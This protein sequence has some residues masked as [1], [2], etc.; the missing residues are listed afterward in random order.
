MLNN[1]I[2]SAE[3]EFNFKSLD[4]VEAKESDFLHWAKEHILEAID[5]HANQLIDSNTMVQMPLLNIDLD[6]NIQNRFFSNSES[7]E[8][9]SLISDK[10][11]EAIQK[12]LMGVAQVTP[13][14][15]TTETVKYSLNQYKANSVLQYL[16]SGQSP[17]FIALNEW[18][19][20][21]F[22]FFEELLLDGI[23]RSTWVEIIQ[24]RDALL[25]FLNLKSTDEII[26]FLNEFTKERHLKL[27]F[28]EVLSVI[29]MNS[30]FFHPLSLSSIV[31][32]F[33]VSYFSSKSI[34]KSFVEIFKA[35]LK[36][37][38][39]TIERLTIPDS[40]K[41]PITD[42]L[43]KVNIEE[44]V[45]QIPRQESSTTQNKP[46]ELLKEGA[47]VSQAGLVLLMPFIN[48][49]LKNIGYVSESGKLEK[50]KQLPI[51]LHY[52][53]TGETE[54]AE[55]NLTLPK[56]LAGLNPGQHCETQII[57]A[58]ALDT[59]INDLLLSVIEHWS[60]LQKT[61]PEG[62]RDTF[63]HREATIKAKN[64]FYYLYVKET[65]FDILL[66]FVP[67]NYTT[68][69]LDWM[70]QILFVEWKNNS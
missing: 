3:L 50:Q 61:S 37:N 28:Q 32:Y 9:K 6:L 41:S 20:N 52:M 30:A 17:Y 10:I 13:L 42:W 63:L 23:Y 12:Q 22:A 33:F 40:T 48:M 19:E 49:F 39:V 59:Q 51:L 1:T 2:H 67:W 15:N 70:Q 57:G 66:S 8:I 11:K 35:Q 34:D 46:Q 25:R 60:A 27:W 56:I 29:E 18:Q 21:I 55:W 68:I 64:G 65:A 36:A 14:K 45:K 31:E 4:K 38:N 58:A 5:F 44:Y 69:K 7:D 43:K 53:A 26:E 62:L 24:N 16:Q 54:T 47:Y